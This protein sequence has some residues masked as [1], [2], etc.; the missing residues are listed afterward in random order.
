MERQS[1]ETLL[2]EFETAWQQIFTIDN[3]RGTYFLCFSA[4][5]FLI[6]AS[7]VFMLIPAAPSA[8]IAAFGATIVLLVH[9]AL[10]HY[11]IGV[12]ESER[13]ANVRYRRKINFIRELLL[14]R[15]DDESIKDYLGKKE[16][17]I[18]TF[19]GSGNE[20]D[21]VGGTLTQIYA[22]IRLQQGAG[23]G[24]I[25]LLWAKALGFG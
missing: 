8:T 15:D 18:K 13:A 6:A 14:S 12:Y 3:R 10:G 1:V 9:V 19:S 5:F 23:V 25:V 20:I 4:L 7:A 2:L 17:G 24:L 16:I 22:L 21:K 11:L